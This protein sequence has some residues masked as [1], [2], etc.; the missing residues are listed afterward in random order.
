MFALVKVQCWCIR[1]QQE[2]K[3]EEEEEQEKEEEQ[4]EE[5]GLLRPPAKVELRSSC[6]ST[7]QLCH[8]A[9]LYL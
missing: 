2:E 4:E 8:F 3:E 6:S 5:G 9:T 7:P 1:L